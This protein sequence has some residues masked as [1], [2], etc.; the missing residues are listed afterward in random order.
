MKSVPPQALADRT[1]IS[2]IHPARILSI[3]VPFY[4][5]DK[6]AFGLQTA[7]IAP[8]ELLYN[9]CDNRTSLLQGYF[10]RQYPVLLEP[11]RVISPFFQGIQHT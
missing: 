4:Q 10:T 2:G 5:H 1:A 8:Q 9:G 11:A 6:D 3:R 7:W